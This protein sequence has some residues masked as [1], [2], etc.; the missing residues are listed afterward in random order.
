[1]PTNTPPESA[2]VEA[3]QTPTPGGVEP[4][5]GAPSGELITRPDPR[6][7]RAIPYEAGEMF[8]G[9]GGLRVIRT[10][11]D[12][13]DD[14]RVWLHVSFS[15]ENQ[16]PSYEDTK[17]VREV[18]VGR[19]ESYQVSPPPERHV[20]IHPYCLH[21]WACLEGPVLPDFSF[22]GTII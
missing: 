17:L 19:H 20:N 14:G 12:C 5:V 9:R 6:D 13:S 4:V 3:P 18:F 15:R 10:V 2:S 1:M 22:N 11:N 8:F 16:L 7:W 21:L